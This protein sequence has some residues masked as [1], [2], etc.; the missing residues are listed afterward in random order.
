MFLNPT[1]REYA[2][3][4]NTQGNCRIEASTYAPIAYV[5]MRTLNYPTFFSSLKAL[6]SVSIVLIF[7]AWILKGR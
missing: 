4:G 5:N 3:Q 7:V 2:L 6:A 1:S